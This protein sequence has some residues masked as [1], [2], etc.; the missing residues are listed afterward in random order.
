[1]PY[2]NA[3]SDQRVLQQFLKSSPDP[4]W[5]ID[6]HR[7][8]DCNEI[9]LETLGYTSRDQFLNLHPSVLSP[10]TQADGED[11]FSKAERMMAYANEKGLHRFEWIHTKADGTNFDAEVTLVSIETGNRRILYCVWRDMTER[12]Q[13]QAACVKVSGSSGHCPRCRPTGSGS[14]TRDFDSSSSLVALPATS[15]PRPVRWEKHGGN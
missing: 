2:S 3:A 14:K 5:I 12:K 6:G 13:A 15:P 1:M 10:P 11:S 9:A 8:V 7:F 4:A